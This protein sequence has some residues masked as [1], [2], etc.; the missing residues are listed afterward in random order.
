MALHG[1]ELRSGSDYVLDALDFDR[2]LQEAGSVVVAEGR[3][4]GQSLHG[5]IAGS[6]L[7]R[8]RARGIAV[9]AVVGSLDEEA[10]ARDWGELR[11]L[12]VAGSLAELE[13]AGA[14]LA[15]L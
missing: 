10:V 2:R 9:H 14:R 8:A 12:S 1:A 5:K 7:N 4:D 15:G 3:L 6:I 13:R 11:S